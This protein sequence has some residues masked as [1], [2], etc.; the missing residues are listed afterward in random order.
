[1]AKNAEKSKS[2]LYRWRETQLAELGLIVPRS[3]PVKRRDGPV[4]T[5]QLE[6]RRLQLLEQI[7]KKINVI[8]DD[9]K[10]KKISEDELRQ[11]ND[12]INDLM[13]EKNQIE[14]DI[15]NRGGHDYKKNVLQATNPIANLDQ[16]RAIADGRMDYKYYGRSV[17]L[18]EVRDLFKEEDQLKRLRAGY[19]QDREAWMKVIQE[20]LYYGYARQQDSKDD[21]AYL[22]LLE[23]ENA[24]Q[25]QMGVS[26]VEPNFQ[27]PTDLPTH[28]QVQSFFVDFKRKQ[29][30]S[31]LE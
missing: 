14:V 1:M 21:G 18:P 4:K 16:G 28:D 19:P 6:I 2:M 31:S 24:A 23:A 10:Q 12:E 26:V 9:I 22:Q 15:V 30:L 27:W 3:K 17:E 7:G 25:S 20:D 29:L 13:R 11:L 8:V 5:S